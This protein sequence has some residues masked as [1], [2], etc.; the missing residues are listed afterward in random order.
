M[1]TNE[2]STALR[3]LAEE[4]GADF[5]GVADLGPARAAVVEQGG[6][7][8]A[9]FPRAVSVGIALPHAIVDQ[10]P[11][12][13]DRAVAMSYRHQAYDIVNQRLDHLVSRL[14]GRLQGHGFR[15]LPVPPSQTVDTRRLCGAFSNKLAAHLAGLGWIG[16]SCLLVTPQAGPRVRWASVLTTGPLPPTG[17]PMEEA[18]GDCRDCVDLCPASAFTGRPFSADEP[19]E[20]RFDVHKCKAYLDETEKARGLPVCGMCLYSCPL[21]KEASARLAA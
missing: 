8:L 10:V 5:F 15:A 13:A 16:K 7:A 2:L 1:G 20:I 11:H 4:L 19:R 9:A 18:C 3:A 14:A 17:G 6:E 21:G 12:R